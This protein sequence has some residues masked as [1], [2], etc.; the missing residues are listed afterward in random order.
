M[1]ATLFHFDDSA[2]L[3]AE[4]TEGI[5]TNRSASGP[6][7]LTLPDDATAGM[8]FEIHQVEPYPITLQGQSSGDDIF[9]EGGSLVL[10]SRGK[11]VRIVYT[12][13][14]FWSGF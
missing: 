5:I 7:T 6:I 2:T 3:A 13:P 8:T 10:D 1:T 11:A 12:G 14:H 4:H 9:G